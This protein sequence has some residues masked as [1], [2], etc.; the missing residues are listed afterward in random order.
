[1]KV[2]TPEQAKKFLEACAYNRWG[3]L[4][5]LLLT[6]GMRPEEALGLKWEDVDF[7]NNR[8]HVKRVLTRTKEGWNLEEPKT[9]KSRRTIPLPKEVIKSLKEHKKNQAEEK[10][11]AK[12]TLNYDKDKEKFTSEELKEKLNDPKI[13]VDYGFVFASQNGSPLEERNVSRYFKELLKK[14]NLPD[15]R[16]YDLRHTC[17]TLLLAAGENPKVVKIQ[18]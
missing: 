7:K 3:V 18:K 8:I 17:A 15:I 14:E 4:F 2:L 12:E 5:E 16:L 6:S 10:L 1:M 9:S 11:K 13:Y